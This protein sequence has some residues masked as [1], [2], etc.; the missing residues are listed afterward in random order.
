MRDICVSIFM[1]TYNQE[2]LITQA[3]EGVVMQKTD[4]RYNLVIGEDFSSDKTRA[5]CEEYAVA[6]PDKIKLLPSKENLGLIKNFIRTYKE[7]DGKYVAICDGDDYWT[8]PLKLQKQVDFLEDHPDF[9][10]VFTSF[11]FLFPD[12]RMPEKDYSKQASVTTFEDLIFENYI[13]SAT[14]VFRNKR[15]P[16]DF[17]GWLDTCPYGDWPL[18]LWATKDGAKIK[19]LDEVTAVY[20]KEI[21][22]SEKLKLV[23]SRISKENL[24]IIERINKDPNFTRFHSAIRQSLKKHRKEIFS[25]LL[26]EGEYIKSCIPGVKIM[27]SNPP[28][29][30]K[31]FS[32][33]FKKRLYRQYKSFSRFSHQ[34]L[35]RVLRNNRIYNRLV[36]QE[37]YKKDR[38]NQVPVLDRS[39]SRS[40]P[41]SSL[42][43]TE[44]VVRHLPQIFKKYTIKSVLDVPCGDFHWM[45]KVDLSEIDYTGGDIVPGIIENN[46]QF[47]CS[48]I[49]FRKIDILNDRLPRVD[50]I[51]CR[52]LFVH[53]SFD[54]ISRA[55]KNIKVSGSKYLLTTSY[56]CRSV[57]H[58]IKEI[59]KWRPLNLE[60]APFFLGDPVEEIFENCTEGNMAYNDKYLLL[61]EIKN[62]SK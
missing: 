35:S 22:V 28:A 26:S 54:Q 12:G 47:S 37:I 39:E 6:N 52:D 33:L 23:P 8:D 29:F 5:I 41:G 34:N 43:Q 17:P 38:F 2:D 55:I 36:F 27:V 61:F 21:G 3:I 30:F 49:R 56:K 25:C 42:K 10:V 7:C 24:N 44:Q 9:G 13:C 62:I 51:F 59:G 4:F 1:L 19:Y 46:K 45:R 16:N 14:A 50:L 57:N 31:L 11:N 53:L 58:D 32:Y 48:N 20:R 15:N 18:Y 40:G 60:I